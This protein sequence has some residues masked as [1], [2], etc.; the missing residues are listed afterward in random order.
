[1]DRIPLAAKLCSAAVL[2]AVCIAG[3]GSGT[4]IGDAAH[5]PQLPERTFK[6][7]IHPHFTRFAGALTGGMRVSGMLYPSVP[8]Y[9]A[10]FGPNQV[11]L[12]LRLHGTPVTRGS[13]SMISRMIGM[14]MPPNRGS[15][16]PDGSRF[17][18][19]LVIP[20]FGSYR[21]SVVLHQG[22][23]TYRGLVVIR[24]PL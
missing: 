23:R 5:H 21:V 8:S 10:S 17:R 18:G 4:H 1:M 9:D 7:T 15:A 12:L 13:I 2:I 16:M 22:S 14:A 6:L 3:C 20:M 11:K 24:V 19:K